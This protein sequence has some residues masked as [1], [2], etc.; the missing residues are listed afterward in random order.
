MPKP[1][2]ARQEAKQAAQK[3]VPNALDST[4]LASGTISADQIST[5]SIKAAH[6]GR[7]NHV[8]DILPARYVETLRKQYPEM[9]KKENQ[10]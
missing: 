3:H 8:A 2:K 1:N 4:N 7:L 6:L 9:W 10:E 5:A